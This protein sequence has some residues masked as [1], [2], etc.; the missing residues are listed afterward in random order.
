MKNLLIYINPQRSFS[1]EWIKDGQ[2]L[3]K[4]ETETLLKIQIDN[5]LE[6]GWKPE[7]IMVVM[8]FPW[9]YNG[10]K[11]IEVGD[12]NYCDFAPTASKINVICTLF[13]MGLIGDELYWFHDNDAFQV[14]ELDIDVNDEIALTD[15]GIARGHTDISKRWSTGV[16]FFRR[17]A[18]DT[19][20]LIQ[21]GVN[22]SY[23]KNEEIALLAM[24]RCNY[25]HIND[26]IRKID[27]TYNFA[28]RARKL[29]EQYEVALKPLRVIHFHPL[30]PRKVMGWKNN[31]AVMPRYF[32]ETLSNS[33]KK[34]GLLK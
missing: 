23:R 8:N 11:A 24:T 3:W 15:Y 29:P 27:I 20:K 21:H 13:D 7:D 9:E 32:N 34:H 19:F 12:E 22:N 1:Q 16:L 6:L 30:D 26:K 31:M 14:G 28:S 10:V 5:S 4:D 18:R 33:F 2:S 25:A 17:G